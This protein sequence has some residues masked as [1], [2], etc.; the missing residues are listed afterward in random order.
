MLQSEQGSEVG[1]GGREGEREGG[2][3]GGQSS[4]RGFE[5]QP[6][7]LISVIRGCPI[8]RLPGR[9]LRRTACSSIK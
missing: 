8:D 2:R 7:H 6:P 1:G 4:E 5:V 3:E 9:S